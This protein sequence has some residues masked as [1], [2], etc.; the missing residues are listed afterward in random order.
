MTH[1]DSNTFHNSSRRK[2]A[3][4]TSTKQT[5]DSHLTFYVVKR[6]LSVGGFPERFRVGPNLAQGTSIYTNERESARLSAIRR[7]RGSKKIVADGLWSESAREHYSSEISD[8]TL[9]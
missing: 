9:P 6:K 5:T 7:G 4:A 8:Q 3:H 1:C 2:Q